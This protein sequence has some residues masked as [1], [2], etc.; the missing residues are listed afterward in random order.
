MLR[1]CNNQI[2]VVVMAAEIVV[3]VAETL[4]VVVAVAALPQCKHQGKFVSATIAAK[5][6]S[7]TAAISP[8]TAWTLVVGMR[9]MDGLF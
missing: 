1:A 2:V 5:V 7:A 8:T 3:V 9:R 4:V 6:S